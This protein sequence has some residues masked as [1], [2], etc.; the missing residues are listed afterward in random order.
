MKRIIINVASFVAG[1]VLM[2]FIC[3]TD[4]AFNYIKKFDWHLIITY[5]FSIIIFFAGVLITIFVNRASI[6]KAEKSKLE[7]ELVRNRLD[8]IN[9]FRVYIEILKTTIVY[10]EKCE[11]IE[12]NRVDLNGKKANKAYGKGILF[13]K[14]MYETYSKSIFAAFI[15]LSMIPN[16]EISDWLWYARNYFYMLNTAEKKYSDEDIWKLSVIAFDDITKMTDDIEH[17][18][19]NY[20][21]NI[22]DQ[23]NTFDA[24]TIESEY[25]EESMSE[26]IR[27]T[28]LYKKIFE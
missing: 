9:S 10:D 24:I 15:S 16:K 18:I 6:V 21:K 14:E 7:S 28:D 20:A 12:Q 19:N 13:S 22:V 8:T 11:D 27:N 26:K 25:T 17:I 23:L 2:F 4:F 5:T 1:I 3:K